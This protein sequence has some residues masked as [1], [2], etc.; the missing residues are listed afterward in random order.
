MYKS[1]LGKKKNTLGQNY[2]G[3]WYSQYKSLIAW[4]TMDDRIPT[5][6]KLT[7]RGCNIPSMYISCLSCTGNYFHLFFHC[8]FSIKLLSWFATILNVTMQFSSINEICKKKLGIGHLNARWQSK[9]VWLTCSTLFGI[10]ET[11]QDFRIT[12]I[13]SV[14]RSG[15]KTKRT[16]IVNMIEF[17]ILKALKIDIHSPKTPI[18]KEVVCVG[19][20]WVLEQC[21]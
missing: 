1:T 8:A 3:S 20:K 21:I 19:P 2:M 10:L 7:K 6:E 9:L 15:N 12:I 13:S 11:K 14:S 5:Y 17:F 18:I 4:R 16:T